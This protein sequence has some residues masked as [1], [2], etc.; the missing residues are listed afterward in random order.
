MKVLF[1]AVVHD[2]GPT[3]PQ[4]HN[5]YLCMY[6]CMYVLMMLLGAGENQIFIV[7]RLYARAI[8]AIA[9][10][11]VRGRDKVKGVVLSVHHAHSI[12]KS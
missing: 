10:A 4:Y 11:R 9:H 8:T 5:A 2:E 12:W 6:S 1:L 3:H 7:L